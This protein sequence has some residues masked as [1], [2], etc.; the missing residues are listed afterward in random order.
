MM[1]V[2]QVLVVLFFGGCFPLAA[3][4]SQEALYTHCVQH[5]TARAAGE[6]CYGWARKN[7]L[8]DLGPI[9]TRT[10]YAAYLFC[11]D[12]FDAELEDITDPPMRAKVCWD[13]ATKGPS[14]WR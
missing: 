2:F 10:P 7:G 8:S 14:E 13:F 12:D 4:Q 5:W 9:G 11:R 6:A 3:S 1:R